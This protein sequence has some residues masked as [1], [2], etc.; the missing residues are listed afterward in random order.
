MTTLLAINLHFYSLSKFGSLGTL[1]QLM[2]GHEI[3]KLHVMAGSK[4]ASIN[5]LT[6]YS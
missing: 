2:Q 6:V 4:S 3:E 5:M 1:E